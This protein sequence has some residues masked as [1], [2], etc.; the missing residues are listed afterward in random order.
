MTS[1]MGEEG[2]HFPWPMHTALTTG[3]WYLLHITVLFQ[4]HSVLD[5]YGDLATRS[6]MLWTSNCC[7]TYSSAN[8]L[9]LVVMHVLVN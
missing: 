3:P 6:C 9:P 2:S 1:A 8:M 4:Q 7:M 5:Y